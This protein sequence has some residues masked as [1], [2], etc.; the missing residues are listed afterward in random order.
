VVASPAGSAPTRLF[1]NGEWVEKEW[2]PKVKVRIRKVVRLRRT[3][4][5]FVDHR[6]KN[7]CSSSSNSSRGREC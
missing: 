1:K 3:I 7:E 4:I 2:D 6:N 5:I